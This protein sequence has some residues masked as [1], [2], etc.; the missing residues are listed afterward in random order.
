[1]QAAIC[2]TID[3]EVL[4]LENPTVKPSALIGQV[5]AG[6]MQLQQLV[7]I[8][9]Y[10]FFCSEHPSCEGHAFS[11]WYNMAYASGPYH[12]QGGRY[13]CSELELMERKL[14]Y[15][16]NTLLAAEKGRALRLMLPRPLNDESGEAWEATWTYNHG[17]A[18]ALKQQCRDRALDLD[19][20]LWN[21]QKYGVMV[22]ILRSKFCPTRQ[23]RLASQLLETSPKQLVEAAHYDADFGVGLQAGTHRPRNKAELADKSILGLVD[24]REVWLVPPGPR[25]GKNLLGRALMEVRADL[26]RA[27]SEAL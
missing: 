3:S 11:N 24:G 22:E 4:P 9:D 27:C 8:D 6:D 5:A 23:P 14:S 10:T 12:G 16:R 13:W 21:R 18:N 7:N 1:M 15:C 2:Q 26:L 17:V 20:E 19:V 25:W